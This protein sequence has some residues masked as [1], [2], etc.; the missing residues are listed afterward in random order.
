MADMVMD[1]CGMGKVFMDFDTKVNAP[2]SIKISP[3][4][5]WRH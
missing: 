3:V 5:M 2:I 1:S 4:E